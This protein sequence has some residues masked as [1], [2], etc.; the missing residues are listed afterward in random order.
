MNHTRAHAPGPISPV[1][2]SPLAELAPPGY[3][4]LKRLLDI[5]VSALALV[6]LSPLLG[7]VALATLLSDPRA[8]ILFRQDRTGLGGQ[9]FKV[10]KFRTMVPDADALK[11]ELRHRS[12]VV[13]P[14]FRLPDDPRVTRLGRVLRKTSLDELPQLLNVLRGDMALVGPRPTSFGADTYQMWQTRRLDFRPGITGPWQVHGRDSMDFEQRARLEI[15]FFSRPS[16]LRELRILV[17]T[18]PAVLRRTG[19]A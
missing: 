17:A 7:A 1:R 15:G 8:P 2:S 3:W 16:L 18:I 4:L 19:V 9:R 10:L 6:L 12:V 11:E 5:T 13:W 14:D